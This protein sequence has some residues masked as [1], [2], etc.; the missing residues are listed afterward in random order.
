MPDSWYKKHKIILRTTTKTFVC[1][2]IHYYK[3]NYYYYSGWARRPHGN[4]GKITIIH[5]SKRQQSLHIN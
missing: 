2:I 1:D 4:Y 3:D 5:N